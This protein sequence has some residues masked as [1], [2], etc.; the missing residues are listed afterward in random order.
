[1]AFITGGSSHP[2]LAACLLILIRIQFLYRYKDENGNELPLRVRLVKSTMTRATQTG[3]IVLERLAA[4]GAVVDEVK[5]CDLIQ[6]GAP[7]V[8]EPPIGK[9]L[10][11]PGADVSLLRIWPLAKQWSLTYT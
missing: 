2:N 11:D 1:M 4:A 3:D 6:E 5:A 10:W 7:C 9:D 8:P